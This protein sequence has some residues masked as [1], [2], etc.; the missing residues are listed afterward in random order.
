MNE[1]ATVKPENPALEP[2]DCHNQRLASNVHPPDWKN[3][4]HAQQWINTLATYAFP[5]I[6]RMLVA[7][8][9]GLPGTQDFA[10]S[11]TLA[12]KAS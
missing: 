3:P 2:F 10:C 1:S 12:T 9:N 5:L 6:G 7:G 8:S 11:I 4:K